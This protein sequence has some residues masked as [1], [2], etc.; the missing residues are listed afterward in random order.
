MLVFKL[1]ASSSRPRRKRVSIA[2][3]AYLTRLYSGQ[4]YF[5]SYIPRPILLGPPRETKILDTN[6]DSTISKPGGGT[7]TYPT[8]FFSLAG[9]FQ[10]LSLVPPGYSS[11]QRVGKSIRAERLDFTITLIPPTYPGPP[12]VIQC[13]QNDLRMLFFFDAAPN[14]AYPNINDLLGSTYQDGSQSSITWNRDLNPDY[15]Q[16]FTILRDIMISTP[17]FTESK[18]NPTVDLSYNLVHRGSI[19]SVRGLEMTFTP[20]T[21]YD[22]DTNPM[23]MSRVLTGAI[24][25]LLICSSSTFDPPLTAWG[26]I[27]NTRL[28]YTDS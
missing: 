6:L 18:P 19:T 27:G 7:P 11:Y 28:F 17:P 21:T 25:L 8:A 22:P 26:V 24:H 20:D 12:E 10:C 5:E 4:P 14:K 1:A 13:P 9:W 3:E 16:R 23:V 2:R 15:L